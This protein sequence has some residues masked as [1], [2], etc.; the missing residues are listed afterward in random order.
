M[1]ATWQPLNAQQRRQGVLDE[2]AGTKDATGTTFGKYELVGTYTDD[3]KKDEA[4]AKAAAVLVKLQNEPNV[5]LIGLWAYNPPAILSA[6]K[7]KGKEGQVKIVGFDEDD[8]TL[9]GIQA[10]HIYGTIVQQPYK[11]GYESVKLM[12]A[13]AKG[14]RSAVP[15]NGLMVVPHKVIAKD[16]A[17]ASEFKN[18][19][20]VGAFHKEL[21]ELLGKK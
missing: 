14:D 5:C 4:K 15:A 10:G 21:K 9:A 11:F 13:L 12:A 16:P 3:T 20:E 6:V 1:S 2:L 8:N 7:D 17:L 18:F 19:Q